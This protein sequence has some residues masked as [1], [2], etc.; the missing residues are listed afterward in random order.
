[1]IEYLLSAAGV[2][3]D[4]AAYLMAWWAVPVWA[5]AGTVVLQRLARDWPLER[6]A[7]SGDGF[8]GVAGAF[9]LAV[10]RPFGRSDVRRNLER[11]NNR[12]GATATYLTA[13]HGLTLYY[14]VLLGPLL[15]KDVLL[16]HVMGMV[17]F[18]ALAAALLRLLRPGGGDVPVVGASPGSPDPG[19]AAEEGG[20]H[21]WLSLVIG[22]GGR[23]L[24]W[25]L[26]GLAVGG[27]IGAAGLASPSLLLT[28]LL[29][30]QGLA[31]QVVHAGVGLLVGPLTFMWPVATLF[32]GTFLWK[33][34]LAQAGLVA[35]FGAALLSPQRLRLYREAWGTQR[36]LRWSLAV[37]LAAV[38]A[39]LAVAVLFGL[40]D[41]DIHY[42]LTPE[43]LWRP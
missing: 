10:A 24:G 16:A 36:T 6:W 5:L 3:A 12:A 7:R 31:R 23:F 20:G 9:L 40:T 13:G 18:A 30:G 29:P 21:S 43:Q 22:E 34:G 38:V 26:W 42:K 15:G 11:L 28:D 39:G 2:A 35:F 4:T 32:A 41:L 19:K 8:L 14:V 27:L 1:M 37:A 25:S 33:I 17:V